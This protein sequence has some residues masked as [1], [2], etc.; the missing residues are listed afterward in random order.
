VVAPLTEGEPSR[1]FLQI[2]EGEVRDAESTVSAGRM[3]A[4]IVPK[5]GVSS[6]NE[7]SETTSSPWW[8]PLNFAV[9]SSRSVMTAALHSA[10]ATHQS[11]I[12]AR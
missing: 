10:R 6:G 4:L 12:K 9:S 3:S 1:E 5:G 11:A 2:I 7:S 8:N